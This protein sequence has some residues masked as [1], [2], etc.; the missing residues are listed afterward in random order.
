MPEPTIIGPTVGAPAPAIGGPSSVYQR[1]DLEQFAGKV[2]IAV[3][4]LVGLTDPDAAIAALDEAHV[5]FG[6]ARVQLLGILDEPIG[7]V[8]E[9]TEDTSV[10]IVADPDRGIS[11]RYVVPSDAQHVT[12][13]AIDLESNVVA[14]TSLPNGPRLLDALTGMVAE[15]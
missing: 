13:V 5:A 3:V 1:L 9:R 14:V 11:D 4:F 12:V 10:P 7:A 2:P 15:A 8:I 6:H